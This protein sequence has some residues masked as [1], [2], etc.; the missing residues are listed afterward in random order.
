MIETKKERRESKMIKISYIITFL[1]VFT[2]LNTNSF[3]E[4]KTD[5]S[6]YSAKT[7]LGLLDK[8]RCKKGLPVKERIKP[9][10]FSDLNPLK[11]R[12]KTGKIISEKA[13]PCHELSTKNLVDLIAKLKCEKK[14]GYK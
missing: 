2:F 5:C 13:I 12:D 10:K 1:I 8:M 7:Y 14:F 4:T 9:K 6:K 3:A 11:P